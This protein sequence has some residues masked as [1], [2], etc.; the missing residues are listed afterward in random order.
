[1]MM[2]EQKYRYRAQWLVLIGAGLLLLLLFGAWISEGLNK[3][4][5]KVQKEYEAILR[6]REGPGFDAFERGIFQVDLPDFNRSDRCIS[7]HHG[8]ENPAMQ[9]EPQPHASHPGKF[10]EDHPV[11]QYPKHTGPIHYWNN[12][13]SR[14]PAESATWP[15]SVSRQVMIQQM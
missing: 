3:E 12:P 8:L 13:I 4:W 5:R 7:C 10:L 2:D 1:M 6:E 14:L 15:F 9:L 11:Q